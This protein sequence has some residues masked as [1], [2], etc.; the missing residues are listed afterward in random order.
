MCCGALSVHFK[1]SN[2]C[3]PRQIPFWKPV[4]GCSSPATAGD[5]RHPRAAG[6]FY[7][8][9]CC[10]KQNKLVIKCQNRQTDKQ[11]TKN[12]LPK[13]LSS[14][15]I[16]GRGVLA[17]SQG[18]KPPSG[19]IYGQIKTGLIPVKLERTTPERIV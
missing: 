1:V 15:E 17:L 5:C 14:K 4:D 6:T 12:L 9:D 19:S 8:C 13:E 7:S 2:I 11:T 18:L 3:R 16:P 10:F